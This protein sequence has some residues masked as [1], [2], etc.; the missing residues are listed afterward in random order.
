MVT[1]REAG[2]VQ[3]RYPQMPLERKGGVPPIA[4]PLGAIPVG[5]EVPLVEPTQE[6]ATRALMVA[7]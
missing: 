3:I 4:D 5:I 2:L 6:M 1:A 7:I